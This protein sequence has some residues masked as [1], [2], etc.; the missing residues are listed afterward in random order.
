MSRISRYTTPTQLQTSKAK[1]NVALYARL[2]REDI[3]KHEESESIISQ[4]AMLTKYISNQE[5]MNLVDLY[6]DDGYSGTSFNRPNFDRMWEDIKD[7]KVNCVVV[8]DLSR[9][10]RN[11]IEASNFIEVMFPLMNVRF[12]SIIDNVDTYLDPNSASGLLVSFKNIMNAEY[13]R[14]LSLKVRSAHQAHRRRGEFIGSFAPYGYMKDPNDHH[15][16]IIDEKAANIVKIIYSMYLQ[17]NSSISIARYLNAQNIPTP[18]QYKKEN[19]SKIYSPNRQCKIVMWSFST[20][21][22]ILQHPVYCGDMV[23]GIRECVSFRDK[24]KRFKLQEEWII[25]KNTHEP[26]ISR[27]DFEKTQ[28]LIKNNK[29]TYTK[30]YKEV[31]LS[32]LCRCGDCGNFMTTGHASSPKLFGKYYFKCHS[33]TMDN[34]FCSRHSFR[35]DKLEEVVFQTIKKY[36]DLSAQIDK[37]IKKIDKSKQNSLQDNNSKIKEKLEQDV[38]TNKSLI[39]SLYVDLKNQTI[40]QE[41]YIT[42]KNR[43]EQ[44]NIDLEQQ[45]TTISQS[46]NNVKPTQNNFVDTLSKYKHFDTLTFEMAHELI[47]RINIFENEKIEIIF[48]FKDDFDNVIR[49]LED[50]AQTIGNIDLASIKSA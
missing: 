8:K 20:I 15:K 18:Y 5:D 3:D 50:N 7:K 45:I 1:W 13:S 10:G 35:N 27:E 19:G 42:E 6:V 38:A 41:K 11:D 24:K 48:K 26:I 30:P 21:K 31:I 43:L 23:Q 16:L 2:S 9:F 4:K 46:I 36:I 34:S 14:D 29:K 40:T 37:L 25:V 28:N 39:A 12:I 47:E 44:L 17:G 33:Y 32:G 49:Y 22:T